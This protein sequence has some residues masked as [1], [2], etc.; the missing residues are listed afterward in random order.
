VTDTVA[1]AARAAAGV[2]APGMGPRLV[3][4]VEAA[5][6]A[7][8]GGEQRPGQYDPVAIAGLGI[9]AGGLIVSVAQLA[10]SIVSDLARRAAAPPSPEAVARDVRI[11]LR[12]YDVALSPETDRITEVVITEV[13]RRLPAE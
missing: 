9:A 3:A 6:A 4:E 10:W 2:L 8:D 7:R 12:E 5:L 11:R 1:D 13:I